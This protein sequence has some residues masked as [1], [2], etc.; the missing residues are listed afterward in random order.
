MRLLYLLVFS[1]CLGLLSAQTLEF[2]VPP[3]TLNRNT[4]EVGIADIDGDGVNDIAVCGAQQRWY[5]GPDFEDFYVIGQSDGGP[6]AARIADMNGDGFPDF[7]TSDGAR[8]PEGTI[9]EL[10]VYLH[11]GVGGD[12]TQ[13]WQRIL[14]YSGLVRHQNDMRLVDID[15]DGRLDILEKPWSPAER[16]LMAFQN[17]DIN[18]WT[19]RTFMTGETGKPEGIS[20][21]DLD[22]DGDTEIVQSGVYWDCP[23]NWRTDAY[24]QYFIDDDWYASVYDKTK[25]EVGDINGDGKTDVYIGSAEGSGLKLS[26]YENTGLA[27]DGS[28]IW[29]ERLIKDDAEDYHAI[30]LV[31]IDFDGDLDLVAGKGFGPKG[32]SVFYN[33]G[34]GNFTEDEIHPD[35]NLYTLDVGDLNADGDM[36]IVATA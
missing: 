22:G 27:M 26:W 11:P 8:Q 1:L 21:G 15:G 30:R 33:D 36:D 29:A 25:S 19:V 35:G 7:V 3:T 28:V 14:V 32:I 24:N 23:G 2:T 20:A 4:A 13:P 5:K 12:P 9:G 10:Y 34:D 16:V 18:D 6:Y 31:D 17:P